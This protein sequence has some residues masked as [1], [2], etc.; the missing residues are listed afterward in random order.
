MSIDGQL[1]MA[2][3]Q[4]FSTGMEEVNTRR[5]PLLENLETL[6]R[7][8]D[9]VESSVYESHYQSYLDDKI[10]KTKFD[11][12]MKFECREITIHIRGVKSQLS[13]LNKKYD[14]LMEKLYL[15]KKLTFNPL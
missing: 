13:I 1:V 2:K 12:I 3:I 6:E 14:E 5:I 7:E 4:E 10:A 15:W 9:L 8:K 11:T